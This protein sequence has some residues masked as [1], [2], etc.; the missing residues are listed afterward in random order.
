MEIERFDIPG[1]VVVIPVRFRDSRGFLSEVF[2]EAQFGAAVEPVHFVQENHSRSEPAGTIRGLH[3]QAPPKAQAKLVRVTRGAVWDVAVDLRLGSPTFG[4]HVG[5]EL[6]AE[7]GKQLW[8][9]VGF[10]HG[11]CTLEPSSEVIYKMTAYYDLASSHGVAWDDP[12]L[13]IPWPVDRRRVLLSDR[14]QRNPQLKDTPSCFSAAQSA[15]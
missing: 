1:L 3:F 2:N 5:V 12:D 10:A 14:D 8:I 11:F 4:H 6:T 13:A 9:P 15:T 7:N